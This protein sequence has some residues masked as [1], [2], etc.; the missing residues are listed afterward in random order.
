MSYPV[1]T[2][3]I[4]RAIV[5]VTL[6]MLSAAEI[7]PPSTIVRLTVEQVRFLKKK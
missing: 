7:I 6:T 2:F 4:S 5:Q 1:K 3:D